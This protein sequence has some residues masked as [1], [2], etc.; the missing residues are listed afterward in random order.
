MIG[1]N[2]ANHKLFVTC[3]NCCVCLHHRL[4]HSALYGA[5]EV[6]IAEAQ[7][8]LGTENIIILVKQHLKKKIKCFY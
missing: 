2:H 4:V 3:I 8:I 7:R 1:A 6:E 5:E